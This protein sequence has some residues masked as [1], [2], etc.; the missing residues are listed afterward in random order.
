MGPRYE[1]WRVIAV[2]GPEGLGLWRGVDAGLVWG[3]VA[4]TLVIMVGC[5]SGFRVCFWWFI[6]VGCFF[7]CFRCL[8]VFSG[9]FWCCFATDLLDVSAGLVSVCFSGSFR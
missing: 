4:A 8:A 2:S 5:Y 1:W 3:A 6:W 9:L 7:G